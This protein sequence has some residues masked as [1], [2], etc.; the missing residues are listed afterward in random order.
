MIFLSD[1]YVYNNY[2]FYTIPFFYDTAGLCHTLR[3]HCEAFGF[4]LPS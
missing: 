3:L 1:P 2:F 4:A